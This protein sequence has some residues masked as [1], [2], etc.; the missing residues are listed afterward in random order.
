MVYPWSR[1]FIHRE[2][3]GHDRLFI[4]RKSC[5]KK[6]KNYCTTY[7]WVLGG[8]QEQDMM[9]YED[10]DRLESYQGRKDELGESSAD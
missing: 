7:Y 3:I 5:I 2:L 8:R 9:C 1:T 4:P 6:A 10:K